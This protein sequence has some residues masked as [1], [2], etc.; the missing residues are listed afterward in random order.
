MKLEEEARMRTAIGIATLI[1][2]IGL[3]A[4]GCGSPTTHED[5]AQGSVENSNQTISMDVFG[6]S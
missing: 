3:I 6:M 5:A 4:V 2:L 1:A